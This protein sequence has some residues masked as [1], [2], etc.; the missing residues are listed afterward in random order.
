[1][2]LPAQSRVQIAIV[3]HSFPVLAF[4]ALLAAPTSAVRGALEL[5]ELS[6]ERHDGTQADNKTIAA[7]QGYAPLPHD[8][9]AP[10]SNV[11]AHDDFTSPST[12]KWAEG[13]KKSFSA[14][15][16]SMQ[17]LFGLLYF[18][19]IVCNYPKLP[20]GA[21]ISP[22]VSVFQERTPLG[23]CCSDSASCSIILQACLCPAQRAAHTM[24]AVGILDYWPGCAL[25]TL[26]PCCTL[27][28]VHSFTDLQDKLGAPKRRGCLLDGLCTIFCSCPVIVQDA[29]ALD[30]ITGARTSICGVE[31]PPPTGADAADVGPGE[32]QPPP[33]GADAAGAGPGEN[34]PP[35]TGVDAAGAGSGDRPRS[36]QVM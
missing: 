8:S 34:Q 13:R 29:V 28:M 17:V 11:S 26:M 16:L 20:D 5:G 22:E 25:M 31:P 10:V 27:W 9:A 32:S 30:M 1:M 21:A 23:A 33:T 35:P 6:L 2:F 14:E 7:G 3:F 15:F 12:E 24:D 19:L 4:L 18:V 36:A